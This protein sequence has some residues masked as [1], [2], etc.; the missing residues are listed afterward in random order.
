MS[1]N[2]DTKVVGLFSKLPIKPKP[3]K[4]TAEVETDVDTPIDADTVKLF[5]KMLDMAERG[6]IVGGIAISFTKDGTP[7]IGFRFGPT[8]TRGELLRYGGVLPLV[9][10]QITDF[11]LEFTGPPSEEGGE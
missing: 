2:D 9:A 3:A 4:E 11:L 5:D 8:D 6:E 10:A 1:E 7:I